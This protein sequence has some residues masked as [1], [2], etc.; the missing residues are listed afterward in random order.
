MREEGNNSRRIR[1]QKLRLFSIDDQDPTARQNVNCLILCL[2]VKAD[3]WM[4]SVHFLARIRTGLNH[5]HESDFILFR[6]VKGMSN[7][8]TSYMLL[9]LQL[10]LYKNESW[11]TNFWCFLGW[12]VCQLPLSHQF[13]LP[14]CSFNSLFLSLAIKFDCIHKFLKGKR[15]R[16]LQG[17]LIIII[18]NSLEGQLQ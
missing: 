16:A 1:I 3:S 4:E 17:F 13:H 8:I 15:E 6:S 10:E 11:E 12:V 14:L 9:R 2:H 18:K 7:S 5:F